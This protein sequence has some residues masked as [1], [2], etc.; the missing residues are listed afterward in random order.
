MLGVAS[1]RARAAG[2]DNIRFV[3]ADAATED[4]GRATFDLAFSRFGVMF[5]DDP[6]RA[7]ENVRRALRAAGR[8][9]F[10][11]W[12]DLAANPWF[13]VPAAAIRPYVP[14]QPTP[15]PHAPGPLAFAD[16]A[17]VRGI[18]EGAGFEAVRTE[19]RDANVALGSHA[20]ALDLLSHIG[21]ASRLLA[22]LDEHVRAQ[23]LLALG[24]VLREHERDGEVAIMGGVWVVSA[25]CA[26]VARV[27]ETST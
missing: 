19:A 4:V 25:R 10:V 2:L 9:V 23:A 1:E 14:P 21:P 20:A 13:A 18:L 17:R 11:C 27:T 22:G 12:R 7:F 26:N 8:I 5:F 24:D 16:A 6:L 15:D 3:L